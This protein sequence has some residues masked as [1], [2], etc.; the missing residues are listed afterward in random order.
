MTM[1]SFCFMLQMNT[2]SPAVFF[3][4]IPADD[5]VKLKQ[6]IDEATTADDAQKIINDYV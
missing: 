2:V 4:M 5:M 3:D 1:Q 6:R